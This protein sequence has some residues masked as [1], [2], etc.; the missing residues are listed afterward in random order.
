MAQNLGTNGTRR[1]APFDTEDRVR[2][3]GRRSMKSIPLDMVVDFVPR[4]RS[5]GLF[6][7]GQRE[8][9]FY[10]DVGASGCTKSSMVWIRSTKSAL[11]TTTN[12]PQYSVGK[13]GRLMRLVVV[14]R[15]VQLL[16]VSALV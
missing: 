16:S 10:L 11:C 12:F 7:R 4:V 1:S 9:S 15:S 13:R 3:D 6:T 2:P 14:K 8:G 5:S